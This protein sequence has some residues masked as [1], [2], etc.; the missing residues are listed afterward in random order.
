MWQLVGK[1]FD[2]EAPQRGIAALCAGRQKLSETEAPRVGEAKLDTAVQ[3]DHE[4]GVGQRWIAGSCRCQMAGHAQVNE[5]ASRLVIEQKELAAAAS[6]EESPMDEPAGQLAWS[7]QPP[8]GHG[9]G[10]QFRDPAPGQNE[11]KLPPNRFDFR[12]LRHQW[13]FPVLR[14]IDVGNRIR[15]RMIPCRVHAACIP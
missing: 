8:H 7:Q 12:Q 2:P 15:L 11:L 9:S 3:A 6:T 13:T 10:R 14:I 5:Q 4:M 1:G